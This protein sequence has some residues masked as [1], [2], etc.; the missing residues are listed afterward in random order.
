M[1]FTYCLFLPCLIPICLLGIVSSYVTDKILLAYYFS[2][3]PQYDK[4]MLTYVIKTLKFAPTPMFLIGYWVLSNRQVFYD[5]SDRYTNWGRNL[6]SPDH[7]LFGPLLEPIKKR[8]ITLCKPSHLM[9]L[10]GLI[11]FI[12]AL[13][14]VNPL[15]FVRKHDEDAHIT[16]ET[17]DYK[18]YFTTLSPMQ[19]QEWIATELY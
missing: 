8:D 13:S 9:F 5:Q 14:T 6:P 15:K 2:Q 4:E 18:E 12:G 17:E 10:V 11:W 3:P 1:M 7:Y 16:S 19:R